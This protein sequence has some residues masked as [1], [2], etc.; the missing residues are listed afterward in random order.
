MPSKTQ[1]L[2]DLADL[3]DRG[4]LTREEFEEEK[5]RILGG[6]PSTHSLPAIPDPAAA[7]AEDR[8][9]PKTVG[10][11]TIANELAVDALGA[12]YQ[13]RHT[14]ES[15][16]ERQGGD[17]WLRVI[18]PELAS[19]EDFVA[20]VKEESDPGL[21]LTH[22]NLADVQSSTI[23]AG[24]VVVAIRPLGGKRLSE[25]L[26]E[27]SG[28][29]PGAMDVASGII[30]AV[31]YAHSRGVVHGGLSP[32]TVFVTD[33]G[34]VVVD[35]GVARPSGS[36]LADRPGAGASDVAYI[37][38]ELHAGTDTDDRA[39]VWSIGLL[40]HRMLTGALPWP[41]A[42]SV[43]DVQAAKEVGLTPSD[44]LGPMA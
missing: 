21:K 5:K 12:W 28:P 42:A 16:A 3:L 15:V 32:D 37:A 26:A 41:E 18:H 9:T 14:I 33:T 1:Q 13:G 25:L 22:P 30:D 4:L 2:K 31:G 34:A 17:V 40:L 44:A 24:L 35:A 27:T 36:V 11:Y 43:S 6:P 7:A 38:P 8:E 39:D 29:L 19:D 23:E 10:S 20:R